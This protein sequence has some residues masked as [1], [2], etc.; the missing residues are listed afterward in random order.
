MRPLKPLDFQ[1]IR[2]IFGT[3]CSQRASVNLLPIY[4]QE[5]H[6][7]KATSI[8][9]RINNLGMSVTKWFTSNA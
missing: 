2:I 4:Q 8:G 6:R 1:K 5:S 7:S 9:I 3:L